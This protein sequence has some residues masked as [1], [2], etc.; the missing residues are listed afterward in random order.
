VKIIKTPKVVETAKKYFGC[1]TLQGVELEDNG[2]EGTAGSHWE[3]RIMY[4][5]FM[6]GRTILENVLSEISLALLE[7][8]GWY[9]VNYYTGGFFR[10]G[11]GKGCEFL[12]SKCVKENGQSL[13]ENEFPLYNIDRICFASRTGKGVSSLNNYDKDIP[14]IYQYFNNTKYGGDDN[15]DYCPVPISTDLD[16]WYDPGSCINGNSDYI[17]GLGETIGI[18]SACFYSSLTKTDD[19]TLVKDRLRGICYEYTCNYSTKTYSVKILDQTFQCDKDGGAISVNGFDGKFWC[20]DFNLVCTKSVECG[21]VIDCVN[22]KSVNAGLN[23]DYT[24][25]SAQV[26]DESP[27]VIPDSANFYNFS[28]LFIIAFIVIFA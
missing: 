3:A 26:P 21:D 2:G 7:D 27:I 16:G 23:Y 4:S 5:D 24:P 14:S 18:N 10:Y 6:I 20:A 1:S 17:S 15:A 19:A 13:S 28:K 11:K 25:D 22:K 9:K 12:N 8:S